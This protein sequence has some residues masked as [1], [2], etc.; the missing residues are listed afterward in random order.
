MVAKTPEENRIVGDFGE[1]ALA[2]F[3]TKKGIHI[4]RA[5]TVFFDLIAKDPSDKLF[6]KKKI[7]EQ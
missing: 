6:P 7:F 2:Y 1:Y 4:F 3:L 5:D